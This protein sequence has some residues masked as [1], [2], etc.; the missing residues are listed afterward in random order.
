LPPYR[1][2]GNAVVGKKLELLEKALDQL[3]IEG[4]EDW[5]DF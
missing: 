1:I 3:L 4:L 2:S 5:R